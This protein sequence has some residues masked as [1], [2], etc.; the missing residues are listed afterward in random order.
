MEN[1]VGKTARGKNI[2]LIHESPVLRVYGKEGLVFGSEPGCAPSFRWCIRC[3]LKGSDLYRRGSPL[4]LQKTARGSPYG[5]TEV[6]WRESQQSFHFPGICASCSFVGMMTDRFFTPMAGI[7]P[8]KIW[9]GKIRGTLERNSAGNSPVQRKRIRETP[10]CSRL[11]MQSC[12]R[13]RM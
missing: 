10:C 4:R 5:D 7:S 11:S 1:E 2:R 3:S 12:R 8:F 6:T 9:S 13:G